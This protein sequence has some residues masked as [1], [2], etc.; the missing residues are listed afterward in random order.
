MKRLAAIAVLFLLMAAPL[1][2]QDA[3]PTATAELDALGY[4]DFDEGL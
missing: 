4:T 1:S 3:Q 2:A